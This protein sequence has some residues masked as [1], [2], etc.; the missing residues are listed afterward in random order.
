MKTK[1]TSFLSL[2]LMSFASL[3]FA[4]PGD[5]IT[6]N[7]TTDP[8]LPYVTVDGDLL[9][10]RAGQLEIPQEGRKPTIVG[11]LGRPFVHQCWGRD[12]LSLPEDDPGVGVIKPSGSDAT[13]A[14]LQG[15]RITIKPPG[16]NAI[17][18]EGC[19]QC[20]GDGGSQFAQPARHPGIGSHRDD[21]S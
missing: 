15:D 17:P 21:S 19:E 14:L 18:G 11:L 3:I 10:A 1:I 20:Y 6:E 13:V 8:G 12:L 16:G 7:N 4:N 9:I 2:S 5:V